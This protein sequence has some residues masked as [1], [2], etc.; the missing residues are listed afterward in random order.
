M[1]PLFFLVFLYPLLEL[2]LLIKVGSLIGAVTVLAL[3]LGSGFLGLAILRRASWLALL[4]ARSGALGAPEMMLTDGVL[5][6]GAGLLLFLPGLLGDLL[7]V[8]LLMPATR[9]RLGQRF[10]GALNRARGGAAAAR[11]Q[12]DVIEGDFTREDTR[13]D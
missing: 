12:P 9:N 3:V 11:R 6:A 10:F 4:R 1:R 13:Q 2:W 5:L 7:G 8:L